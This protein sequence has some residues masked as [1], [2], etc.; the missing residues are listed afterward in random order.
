ARAAGRL[1]VV[2]GYTDVMHCHQAG[3][4]EVAAGLGTALTP[5]NAQQL[6]RF[7]VPIFLVFDGDEAGRKAAERAAEVL[8]AGQVDGAVALLPPGQDPADIVLQ[9][10][11]P[12]LEAAVE[13]ATDLWTYRMERSLGRHGSTLEGREKAAKELVAVIARI[14]DAVRRELAFRLLAERTGVPESTLRNEAP[15]APGQRTDRP[16]APTAWVE[17]ER[18]F[19]RAGLE[20]ASAW[21]RVER[22]Y[23][24]DRFRDPA[25][26]FVAAALS[27]LRRRGE[28]VTREGLLSVLTDKDEA[29]R[30]LQALEPAADARHRAE[31]HLARL[32]REEQVRKAL[33][34]NDLEGVVRAR[35]DPSAL[36]PLNMEQ[37]G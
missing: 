6:R 14:G 36:T 13:G 15:R 24:P 22:C 1:L 7:G 28:S 32:A 3:L 33:A 20:D 18:D 25:L 4:R 9:G 16:D 26:R 34:Q 2:E 5:E 37:N 19:V 21:G 35:K 27:D 31:L 29:V 10:G 11:L 17:A 8:L 23:P 30:A 12:V